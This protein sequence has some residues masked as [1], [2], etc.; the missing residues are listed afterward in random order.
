[1]PPIHMDV[2]KMKQVL[3]NLLMNAS[4]AIEGRGEIIVSSSCRAS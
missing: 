3:I 4:Q 1:M 2:N